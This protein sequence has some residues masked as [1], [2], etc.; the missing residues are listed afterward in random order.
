MIRATAMLAALLAAAPAQSAVFL[1]DFEDQPLGTA[2][3]PLV[4]PEASFST[5]GGNNIII[6][7]ETNSLCPNPGVGCDAVLEVQ[8]PAAPFYAANLTFTVTGDDAAGDVGDVFVYREGALLGS[9]DLFVDGLSRTQDLI[10]LTA[11]PEINRISIFTND[12][13]GLATTISASTS[14]SST[15]PSPRLLRWRCSASASLA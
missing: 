4:Y 11:F 13:L 15:S 12:S 2:A 7:F 1:I 9:V 10:H 5:L 14:S 6:N 3:N 8:F